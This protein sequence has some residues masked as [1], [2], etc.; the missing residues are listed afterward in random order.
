[1]VARMCPDADTLQAFIARK[2]D[3]QAT[4]SVA[5]HLEGCDHCRQLVLAVGRAEQRGR[6]DTLLSDAPAAQDAMTPLSTGATI[7]RYVLL[8]I[9]GV[10]GMGV[11]YAAW[12]P[13]LERRVAVKLLRPDARVSLDVLQAR[14]LRE[15]QAMA[16]LSHP[17]VITIHEVG[18]HDNHVFVV[19]E[20]VD[21]G[22]LNDWLRAEQRSWRDIVRA[23]CAAGEGLSAA[24]S[25]G[26]VHRDFKPDN[27]LVRSDGRFGVTD[28]GLA[29][30]DGD[31][32]NVDE[33]ELAG[34]LE[35]RLT[36][37]GAVV[38]TPAYMAPEQ[39]ASNRCDQRSD[40][41]SFCIALYEA[42][43]GERPFSGRNVAELRANVEKGA[44]EPRG[45]VPPFVTRA[46]MRGLRVNPDERPQTMRALIDALRADPRQK[47][48]RAGAI[49]GMTLMTLLVLALGG[50]RVL[51]RRHRCD[52]VGAP[53]ENHWNA[54]A[55]AAVENAFAASRLPY[56]A[57]TARFVTQRLDQWADAWRG[58]RVA[59][60]RA[61]EQGA[62]SAELYD[63]RMQCL[64]DRLIDLDAVVNEL[65]HADASTVRH[66][67]ELAGAI[68]PLARCRDERSLRAV[69]A[70]KP[71]QA[72]AVERVREKLAA[73]RAQ[74]D[75]G[76]RENVRAEAA[77]A[78]SDARKIDYADV[79]AEALLLTGS[80]SQEA[81]NGDEARRALSEA[82][83]LAVAARDERLLAQAWSL[84][85]FIDGYV[86][87]D[88]QHGLEWLEL[89]RAL[90]ARLPNHD[91][92]ELEA[93]HRQGAV[94]DLA[95]DFD[96]LLSLQLQALRLSQKVHGDD[97]MSTA[98]ALA[99]VGI[100]YRVVGDKA[101]GSAMSRRALATMEK[102]VGA[103]HPNVAAVLSNVAYLEDDLG[104][105]DAALDL[106]KRA[107]AIYEADY[108]ATDSAL[109][110]ALI[111]VAIELVKTRKLDEAEAVLARAEMLAR[112]YDARL[113]TVLL[114]QAQVAASRR[115][116]ARASTLA[117][118]A[119]KAGDIDAEDRL[120]LG[121]LLLAAGA[122]AAGETQIQRSIDDGLAQKGDRAEAELALA[123][124]LASRDR[125]RAAALA[126][127]AVTRLAQPF[128]DPRHTLDGARQLLQTLR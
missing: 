80:V 39:L 9:L 33:R 118:Q 19:M 93:L 51:A 53:I 72:A 128:G 27:V 70:P 4:E 110:W 119:E 85:G 52:A 107:L 81:A 12:D 48:L 24:H 112:R 89:S 64:D 34:R 46:V 117:A 113:S 96:T 41:F 59:A 99:G 97:D 42:L 49:A 55:R 40:L 90:I 31:S 54:T 69:A 124:S 67:T 14:L 71:T 87:S 13:K 100:A 68:A 50:D 122:R 125:A 26:L 94:L 1:M 102:L 121:E 84:R 88:P 63:L 35:T 5:Q 17:N 106:K 15:A 7:G 18:T 127:A 101:L 11:V 109:L 86:A 30:Q 56:A 66:A 104:H 123:R 8:R 116:L 91:E 78:V 126:Q 3:A 36:R 75:A 115:Q 25:A 44:P 98:F 65:Q 73:V 79:L 58:D 62:Q 21:G 92:L 82:A 95:R 45:K 37:T 10:G 60:C 32:D 23:F 111:D 77:A 47:F 76:K 2:L 20:F 28:F 38:G 108:G 22:T 74:Y 105:F 6:D 16:R 61:G 57:S 114:L 29:R 120:E 43:Y 103:N 83:A